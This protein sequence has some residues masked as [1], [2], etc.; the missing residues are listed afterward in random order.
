MSDHGEQAENVHQLYKKRKPSKNQYQYQ[1][2]FKSEIFL[3][4][5]LEGIMIVVIFQLE[6]I[7][8]VQ[9]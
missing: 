9:T 4:Q 5:N 1:E 6:L 2:L 7:I 8:K 3:N